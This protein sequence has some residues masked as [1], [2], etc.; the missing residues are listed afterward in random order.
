MG[1][2]GLWTI[3]AVLA[4]AMMSVRTALAAPAINEQRPNRAGMRVY[5]QVTAIG[6]G[7]FT[8]LLSDGREVTV[9]VDEQTRFRQAGGGEATFGDLTVGRWVAGV[10][11][12]TD[13]E[14]VF[15]ARVVV[16]L[17]EDFDPS[18]RLGARAAGRVVRV[19]AEGGTFVLDTRQGE[20]TVAVNE[21]TRFRGI[22]SLGDLQPGMFAA[23]AGEKQDDG[24]L[25]ARVVGAREGKRQVQ[26]F[27][28]EVTAVDTGAG[29]FALRTRS[30][31]TVNFSVTEKT[32]YQGKI[33]GLGDLQP[34]MAA[35]VGATRGDNGRWTALFVAA[36]PRPEVQRFVGQVMAVNPAAGQLTLKTREG[37]EVI[38]ATTERT[39][40]R[41][42]QGLDEVQPGM[43][44][45]VT[46]AEVDG[47]WVAL[48]VAAGR[49]P[50]DA[51][52]FVG[53]VTAVGE[54]EFTLNT[55]GDGQVTL[56]VNDQTRF[57][58]ISGLGDLNPG[59]KAIALARPGKDGGWVALAVGV[60]L[61]GRGGGHQGGQGRVRLLGQVEAANGDTLTLTARGGQ[62]V[63]VTVTGQTRFRGIGGLSDLQPG[64]K[65]LVVAAKG[66]GQLQALLVA[67][68]P[69]P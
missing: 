45:L 57:R 19:D 58:G 50:A 15:L 44:A 33:Q 69:G 48:A 43:A 55:Q 66:D 2:K 7:Q 30:G 9:R 68:R 24:T 18:Q 67:A 46:A 20:V 42:V 65:V 14:G 59:M 41:G 4:L 49:K 23:A 51:R 27:A 21:A 29:A 3:L 61:E 28:G 60:R 56:Q 26:R 34:G 62:S 10:G 32:R 52:R 47:R 6:D 31:E 11:R 8:L 1:R 54:H 63:T 64:Q 25:L 35:V 12:P 39:R 40:Y 13:Q 38:F 53:V 36:G 22:A 17:P 16:L 37:Q 5:G